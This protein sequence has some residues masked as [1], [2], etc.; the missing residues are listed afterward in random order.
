MA[1]NPKNLPV[2]KEAFKLS[3]DVYNT[4]K[5]VKTSLRLKEQL[6]GS[7]SSVCANL[8]EM[9]AFESQGQQKQKIRICIGECNEAEYWFDLC[10]EV[11][12]LDGVSHENFSSRLAG[13]RAMLFGLLK[14]ISQEK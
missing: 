13:V 7:V 5:E 4:F 8:A 3:V 14:S 1:Q 6:F 10:K 11:C 2:Y 9:S 12:L